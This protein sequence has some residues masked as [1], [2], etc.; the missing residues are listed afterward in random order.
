MEAWVGHRLGQ[1]LGPG[2]RGGAS[3]PGTCA[4]MRGILGRW[5][6]GQSRD[7]ACWRGP[8]FQLPDV[9]TLV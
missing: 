8:H 1:R 6:E 5:G 2:D 4:E 3:R 7:P 9:V